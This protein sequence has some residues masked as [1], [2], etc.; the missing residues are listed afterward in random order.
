MRNER[1]LNGD[2]FVCQGDKGSVVLASFM[3]AWHKLGSTERREPLMRK[4]LHKIRQAC[5]AFS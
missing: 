3:S 1:L 5:R 4:C 2:V